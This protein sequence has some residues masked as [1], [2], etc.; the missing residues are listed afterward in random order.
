ME[1]LQQ[2]AQQEFAELMTKW[3]ERIQAVRDVPTAVETPSDGPDPKPTEENPAADGVGLDVV[4]SDL[5]P[6]R[7]ELEAEDAPKKEPEEKEE[8]PTVVL[9]EEFGGADVPS[10][11]SEEKKE[12]AKTPEIDSEVDRSAAKLLCCMCQKKINRNSNKKKKPRTQR[13]IEQSKKNLAMRWKREKQKKEIEFLEAPPSSP[14]AG[15][16]VHSPIGTVRKM[17][18]SQSPGFSIC[19]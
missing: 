11:N 5:E 18:G 14:P 10:V 17:V 13:Q 7:S 9:E 8:P 2:E 1:A 6:I 19:F 3:S 12:V 16:P 15:E 4:G